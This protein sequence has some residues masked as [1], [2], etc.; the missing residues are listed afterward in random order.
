MDK[1]LN[2]ESFSSY[3]RIE[4]LLVQTANGDDYES[5]F[6]LRKHRTAEM[7]ILGRYLGMPQLSI[8]EALLKI[9]CFDDILSAV[10]KVPEPEKKFV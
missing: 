10:T 8:L 6:N 7:L 2:Q 9:S 4:T 1:R 3:A 5:E